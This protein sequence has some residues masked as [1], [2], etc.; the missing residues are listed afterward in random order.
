MLNIKNKER[1]LKSAKEK[2]QVT[3]KVKLIRTEAYYSTQPLNTRRSSKDILQALKEKQLTTYISVSSKAI[4]HIWRR[5]K[6]L[7]DQQKLKDFIVTKPALQKTHKWIL[8]AEE[9]N[10]NQENIG[11]SK[12]H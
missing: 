1:Q 4:L 8:Y 5:N 11:N 9:D 7:H 2:W 10:C 3:Y 12:S 6:N